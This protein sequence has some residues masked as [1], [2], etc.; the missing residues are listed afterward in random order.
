[1]R[2][3]VNRDDDIAVLKREHP[4]EVAGRPAQRVACSWKRLQVFTELQHNRCSNE[5]LGR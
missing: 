5:T 2:P 1:V 4:K 3:M